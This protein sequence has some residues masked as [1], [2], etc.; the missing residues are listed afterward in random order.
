M[1]VDDV[2]C[3]SREPKRGNGVKYNSGWRE[4]EFKASDV[5][6]GKV[7]DGA[8]ENSFREIMRGGG[9]VSGDKWIM[10]QDLASGGVKT[11]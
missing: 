11:R 1:F 7:I 3:S 10:T 8:E 9:R 5:S 6:N 2:L 4:K